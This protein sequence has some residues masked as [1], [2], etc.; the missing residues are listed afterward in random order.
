MMMVSLWIRGLIVED[1]I[2]ARVGKRLYFFILGNGRF[3]WGRYPPFMTSSSIIDW[4]VHQY[5][6]GDN[7]GE[8]G[9]L[10]KPDD[11]RIP[12]YQLAVGLT[13]L[14]TVLLLWPARKQRPQHAPAP[15]P[16]QRHT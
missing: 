11:W 14:A 15:P 1:D 2:I 10:F 16:P 8:T 4:S 7:R 6:E 5:K 3:E 12:I 9:W 13:F